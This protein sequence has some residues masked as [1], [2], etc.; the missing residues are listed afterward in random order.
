LLLSKGRV[1][2]SD[3][4]RKRFDWKRLWPIWKNNPRIFRRNWRKP[5]KHQDNRHLKRESNP[6]H[7]QN[8]S[9]YL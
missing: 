2:L 5:R 6:G 8:E 9:V 7:L 3:E 4:L 1:I